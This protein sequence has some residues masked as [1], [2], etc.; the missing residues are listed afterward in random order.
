MTLALD[1]QRD[2]RR[3]TPPRRGDVQPEQ[4]ATGQAQ[5]KAKTQVHEGPWGHDA[6]CRHQDVCGIH[7]GC[8]AQPGGSEEAERQLAF[9][10]R[11]QQLSPEAR[12]LEDPALE[13]GMGP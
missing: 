10:A 3:S 6:G 4:G 7:E 9:Q 13:K 12:T 11:A 2:P 8:G 1:G 5:P